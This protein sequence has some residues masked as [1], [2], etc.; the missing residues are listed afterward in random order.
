MGSERAAASAPK[1]QPV[2][3]PK[4]QQKQRGGFFGSPDVERRGT[5]L[6]QGQSRRAQFLGTA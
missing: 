1:E 5:V 3:Q 2:Q 6:N 4:K